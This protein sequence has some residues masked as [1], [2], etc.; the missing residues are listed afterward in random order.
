MKPIATKAPNRK[1]TRKATVRRA[2][3]DL[4]ER[5]PAFSKLPA[6]ARTQITRDTTLVADYLTELRKGT[7]AFDNLIEEIDFP[8]FVTN[9]IKGVFEAIVK[10][11]IEQMKAYAELV[12]AVAKSVDKFRDENISD[13]QAR[14]YLVDQS[15]NFLK[16]DPRKPQPA[17][18]AKRKPATDRQQLLAT[19]VLMGIN[20]IV[21]TTGKVRKK[22]A[23]G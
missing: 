14:D 15:P 13:K 20:R 7:N 21:V 22:P 6:K 2:V 10:A 12:A 4:L 1:A 8:A 3:K 16:A 11:S 19:M 17:P 5:S 18:R 9:L 23:K